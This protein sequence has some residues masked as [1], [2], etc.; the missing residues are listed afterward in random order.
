[1]PQ[2]ETYFLSHNSPQQLRQVSLSTAGKMFVV[3]CTAPTP[4]LIDLQI[5]LTCQQV[6]IRIINTPIV[7]PCRE[8]G[9]DVGGWGGEEMCLTANIFI[10]PYR[11]DAVNQSRF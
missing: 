1:M 7:D 6:P 8:R 2:V 3:T 10:P 9:G 5:R 11:L 4:T